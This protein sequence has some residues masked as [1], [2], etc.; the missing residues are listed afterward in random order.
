MRRPPVRPSG[1]ELSAERLVA[2]ED[3]APRKCDRECVSLFRPGAKNIREYSRHVLAHVDSS[4]LQGHAGPGAP[5]ALVHTV[6]PLPVLLTGQVHGRSPKESAT[7]GCPPGGHVQRRGCGGVGA[8][9]RPDGRAH[10]RRD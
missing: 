5:W 6:R 4:P 2:E 3:A 7:L 1:L 9:N 10:V 8:Q